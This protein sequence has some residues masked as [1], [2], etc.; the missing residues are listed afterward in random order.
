MQKQWLDDLTDQLLQ[1]LFTADN[2]HIRLNTWL[3][4][5]G[6][7]LNAADW[8]VLSTYLLSNN[9]IDQKELTGVL[10]DFGMKRTTTKLSGRGLSIML[11]HETWIKYLAS[12][13]RQ[14]RKKRWAKKGAVTS[15]ILSVAVALCTIG[16]A[17]WDRK[18]GVSIDELESRIDS[19]YKVISIPVNT[20]D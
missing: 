7:E 5:T 6:N 3:V 18:Q 9:L 15:L 10:A 2:P 16:G 20:R 13:K 11:K 14:E 1:H 4:E 17:L 12:A 19:L 8:Q